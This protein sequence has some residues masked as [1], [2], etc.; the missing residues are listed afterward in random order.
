M[1]NPG[2]SEHSD[3]P[4]ELESLAGC[5]ILLTRPTGRGDALAA[6]ISARGG[7]CMKLPL[8]EIVPVSERG[9]VAR[10]KS[11]IMALD[12]YDMA[13]FISTNA[14]TLGAEWIENYWP[15]LPAGLEAYAVGPG[16]AEILRT[17]PWP[18]HCSVEGVTS[19]DLLALPGLQDVKGKRIALF[20]GQ[21]GREML[22]ESLRQRGARVDY[23]EL[24]VRRVPRYDRGK[25]MQAIHEAGINFAVFTSMQ[26]FDSYLALMELDTA[27]AVA[28]PAG[29]D[30]QAQAT[31]WQQQEWCVIV[32]SPRV[33]EHA[34]SA[35]FRRVVDAG[36]AD[37]R[38]VL[39]ALLQ[40]HAELN[41]LGQPVDK[42]TL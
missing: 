38:S 30:P 14:A 4:A 32:P 40:C 13:I 5:N 15:Q 17:L 33:L 23:L 41:G 24:Y 26:I 19:E 27:P 36:G 6:A 28:M 3:I 22:A 39:S 25:V 29:S 31:R 16:T 2:G 20:R 9:D 42:E 8:L 34:R 12:Q 10:I 7:R 21:G 35:G 11:Q 18:V 1:A 37:D